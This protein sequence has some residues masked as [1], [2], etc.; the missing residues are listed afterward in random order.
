MGW[1]SFIPK[2][3]GLGADALNGWQDRK[4]IKLQHKTKIEEAQV[5]A[6]IKRIES[7][8]EHA[9]MLDK[10]SI[11]QRGWKDDY[12]LILTTLPLVALFVGPFIGLDLQTKVEAGFTALAKTPEYYWYALGI[13]YIDTFGFRR[14]VRV[15]FEKWLTD[16]FGGSNGK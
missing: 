5:A 7:G 6:T 10:E 11:K 14:M 8:D 16:K 3:F 15:A 4:K 2:L 13:I 1:L 9:A 12:L